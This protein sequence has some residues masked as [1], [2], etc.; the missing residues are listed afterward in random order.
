MCKSAKKKGGGMKG[1]VERKKK[2]PEARS[3]HGITELLEDYGTRN[4]TKLGEVKMELLKCPVCEEMNTHVIGVVRDGR[5]SYGGGAILLEGELCGHLFQLVVDDHE[6]L[7][8][9]HV[10]ISERRSKKEYNIEEESDGKECP[11]NGRPLDHVD[12]S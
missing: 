4:S 6:G 9:V 8:F 7:C 1:T 12:K 10:E 11:Y 2:L 3:D 5:G